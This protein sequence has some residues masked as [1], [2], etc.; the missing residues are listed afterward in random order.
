MRAAILV[1]AG[2]GARMGA[3]RNKVLLPLLGEPIV[4]RS[5]R[6]LR[7]SGLYEQIVLVVSC[8]DREAMRALIGDTPGVTLCEGGADRQESVCRGLCALPKGVK[9]VTVHDAARPLVTREILEASLSMAERVGSGVAA[10]PVKDT[11]KIV[12]TGGAVCSTPDRDTLR[13]VQTPQSFAYPLL[14]RVHKRHRADPARATDDAALLERDEITVFL[15]QGSPENLKVTTPEDLPIAEA[16]L[17]R[18]G[19]EGAPMRIGHGYDVHRLTP[20]RKLILCGV[21]I[22]SAL[23]L[24]G[25][26]DADVALHALMDALLGA[27]ALGDIGRHFPD[28]DPAYLGADSGKLLDAVMEMLRARGLAPQSADI[29]LLCQRPKLAPYMA[30]MRASVARR[31][32]L[33]ED[34]VNVKA[35][36]TEGLGFEGEGL[37]ISCHAVC[38]LREASA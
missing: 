28:S 34:R 33:A 30:A 20:D 10:I 35:T 14:M 24:L 27:A 22:P 16:I 7:E 37:G 29:T 1:A 8:E 6:A 26:S 23:G 5:L 15:T 18:R 3:A 38:L 9:M 2:R 32:G 11:I 36:T 17:R 25:H 31:L 21:E 19:E 13:A 12:A 4:L